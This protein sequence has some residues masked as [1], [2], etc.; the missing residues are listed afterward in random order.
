MGVV[1]NTGTLTVAGTQ[2]GT[3]GGTVK[4]LGDKVGMFNGTRIDASGDA[5]GGEILIGGNYQ[6]KGPETNALT[7]TV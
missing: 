7:T 6:G 5:G 4:V 1:A 2:A 3:T